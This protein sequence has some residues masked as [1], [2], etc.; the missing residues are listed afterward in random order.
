MNRPK[1]FL[2]APGIALA[3]AAVALDNRIIGWLAIPVLAASFLLGMVEKRRARMEAEGL[4][5][6]EV[7]S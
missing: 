5:D 7:D 3:L 4:P 6:D 2:A 1:Y